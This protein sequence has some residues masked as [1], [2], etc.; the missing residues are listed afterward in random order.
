[1]HYMVG[2]RPGGLC[3]HLR[4]YTAW[5]PSGSVLGLVVFPTRDRGWSSE[6]SA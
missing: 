1:M 5:D 4:V 2:A 3:V 6:H